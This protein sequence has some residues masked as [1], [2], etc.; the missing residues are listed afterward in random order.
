[1]VF[2]KLEFVRLKPQ[3]VL[4]EAGDTLRSGY[5]CNTGMFSILSVFPN[6]K[7]VEVG[8]VGREGFAGTPL[9]AG[10]A[11]TPT[12]AVVQVEATA[13]RVDADALSEF[14]RRCP[15]LERK[16]QQASQIMAME[17]TQ[18]AACN[19]LHEV[20]QR[21]ARWLLMCEDR[22]GDTTLPLTQ[23]LLAQMLGARRASVTIAAGIL[24]RAGLITY[25][26]GSVR[27]ADRAK[28]EESAC[29]CYGMMQRRRQDWRRES[30]G[31][32]SRQS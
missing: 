22:I 26:R 32:P 7:T 3:H 8:L 19:L 16:L 12:R 5:F 23:E 25:S 14:L 24:K 2:P 30:Q 31:T 4:H 20:E 21:L 28:L 18:I 9:V 10:F 13:L 29:E 17:A 6:G 15:Q 1:M 11:S 27:I